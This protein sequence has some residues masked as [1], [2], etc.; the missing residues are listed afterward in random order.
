MK[1]FLLPRL[2]LCVTFF[3]SVSF[4][5]FGQYK[6]DNSDFKKLY[7]KSLKAYDDYNYQFLLAKE[8]DLLR[9]TETKQD[10]LTALVYSWMA[11][12]HAVE[13]DAKKGYKYYQKELALRQRIQQKE[14]YEY[15]SLINNLAA[16]AME[17]GNY[18]ESEKL[19]LELVQEDKSKYGSKSEE[20]AQTVKNLA[21]LY[22][23]MGRYKDSENTLR[24][25]MREVGVGNAQYPSIVTNLAILYSVTGEFSKSEKT[26]ERALLLIEEGPG[27][28]SLE[29]VK[30]LANLSFLYQAAGR[31]ADAEQSLLEANSILDRLQGEN[32]EVR[33]LLLNY[34][35]A[36]KF[37]LG[38]YNEATTYFTQNLTLDAELYGE[39][40]PNYAFT[41]DALGSVYSY[42]GN[43]NKAIETYKQALEIIAELMGEDSFDY[44]YTQAN[45]SLAYINN[46]QLQ[47]ALQTMTSVLKTDKEVLGEGHPDYANSL[48]NMGN[49]YFKSQN[50]S[51][52][53]K[54]FS[55][56]LKIRKKAIGTSHPKYAETTN[57]LAVLKWAQKDSKNAE[58]FYKETFNNFF[59]Q[60]NA[61]FPI[62]SEDEKATFYYTK[63]RKVFEEF[64]SF[65]V[66]HHQVNP[67]LTGDMYDLQLATKGLILYA[68]NKVRESILNSGD[69][70]L[71]NTFNEWI[72]QKEQIAKLYSSNEEDLEIRNRKIDSLSSRA[73]SLERELSTASAAFHNTYVQ[74]SYTWQNVRDKLKAGEAAVEI[75]RFREFK[76]DSSG[77][78][79]PQVYYAALIVRP[80]T[81]D[82]PDMV[83]I[84]NGNNMESRYLANYRNAI[85]YKVEE[86]Y[87]YQLFWKP[88]AN[89]LA[90]VQKV[91][92][93]PDGVYNQI[94]IYS[95]QNPESGKYI[96]DE[97]AIQVV[98]N[99][100]DLL[101][102]KR[103]P[104]GALKGGK[105][106]LIGYPN[107]HAGTFEDMIAQTETATNVVV[108]ASE[109]REVRGTRGARSAVGLENTRSASR[110]LPRGIRGNLNRYITSNDLLA[111]LPGTKVEVDKIN[112]LYNSLNQASEVVTGDAAVESTMKEVKNPK[113]LHIATHGFFL[114]DPKP[115][116][117]VDIKYVENPL[118]RSGLIFAGANS[119]LASGEISDDTGNED[120]ILTAYEAMNLSLD[121]TDLV[122]LSACETGLGTVQNGEGV[123]G[124]QRA[125]RVA[126]AKSMIMSMWTVDDEATQELM[127]LFYDSWLTTGDKHQSFIS[128]QRE[129]K[130]KYPDPYYWGA[131]VMIGE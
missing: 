115:G 3:L 108:A 74:K 66:E 62:L 56:S 84:R 5:A 57:R 46:D 83:V 34:T 103:V 87:S 107:Y 47:E 1:R 69:S 40:S 99:T 125:F 59:T 109:G 98:T 35:G 37:R 11:E 8:K 4:S 80:D 128:A 27:L 121:G 82:H 45:L 60:I 116:E 58:A 67:A 126:G 21:D 61:Y 97:I 29:Y 106:M 31:Y 102:E 9:Y 16:F 38:L 50:L 79:T 114:E 119:F 110:G 43:Y 55:E 131:F 63:L 65:A 48:H 54:Y 95:L 101:E 52:A 20:Y 78:F 30:A 105:A 96:I 90:D 42:M 49:L 71:I 130:Q 127:T 17:M 13:G 112:S 32:K 85:K 24:R 68:T 33:S 129:L 89:K 91:F 18:E 14:E 111:L 15:G 51:G 120:G 28:A 81:K 26:F 7:E 53:E 117:G 94:S 122:V 124:L 77:Y 44:S 73:N 100:K 92:F 36:V 10:T 70:S 39:I 6:F 25:L 19:F 123:Y 93:S 23:N 104:D 64:N 41:L 75:V 22:Q 72:S 2:V 113:T 76:P 12:S 86:N 88:I 118:L